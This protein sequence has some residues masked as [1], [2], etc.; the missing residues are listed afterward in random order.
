MSAPTTSQA[1]KRSARRG[2]PRLPVLL[3]FVLVAVGLLGGLLLI[4]ATLKAE[5]RERAQAQQTELIVGILGEIG[6]IAVNA[7]TAERGYFIT[8]DERYLRPYRAARAQVQPLSDELRRAVK[9]RSPDQLVLADEIAALAEAKFDAIDATVAQLSAGDRAGAQRRILTDEGALLMDKLRDRIERLGGI[10]A[11]RLGALRQSSVATENRI[12]PLLGALLALIVA[13]L[14]LGLSQVLRA[15]RAE[16]SEA[17]AE[18]LRIARDRADLLASELNHR[19]KNLFAVVLAIV[20]MSGRENPEGRTA[21]DQVAGRIEALSKAH[22]VTQGSAHH[23]VAQL[24]QLVETALA[25]YRTS[26]STCQI[27]G[28]DVALPEAAVVPVGL[29]LHEL[30]T[31]AVKYGAWSKPGGRIIVGWSGEDGQDLHLVWREHGASGVAA[32]APGKEGFG[33][34]LVEGAARQLSG[35]F[36][37]RFHDDGM[38]Q[39]L[40]FPLKR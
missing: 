14:A 6:R 34:A 7:E 4:A 3:L 29:V 17:Q 37:R 31:N 5:Q 13:A 36:E 25:P 11:D 40:A 1:D 9:A 8:S 2:M 33:S 32:P 27:E 30:A 28:P 18:E 19:V 10:E 24:G 26:D 35:R 15:A 39:H 21:I 12:V 16:A 23:R 20:R 38:E 22:A